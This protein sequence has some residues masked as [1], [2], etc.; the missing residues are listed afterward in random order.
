MSIK[1]YLHTLLESAFVNKKEYIGQR[2]YPNPNAAVRLTT[3][4]GDVFV[5]TPPND[6]LVSFSVVQLA[7]SVVRLSHVCWETGFTTGTEAHN[8]SSLIPVRKGITLHINFQAQ[9]PLWLHFIPMEA[10]S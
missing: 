5:Y 6:G 7:N 4:V 2:A 9:E 1:T 10:A 3:T 8:W